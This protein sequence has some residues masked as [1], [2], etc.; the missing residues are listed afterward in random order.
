M[1]RKLLDADK[2]CI[3]PYRVGPS[4]SG[5]SHDVE[6]GDLPPEL[7]RALKISPLSRLQR[8]IITLVVNRVSCT[9][10]GGPRTGR[11]TAAPLT[12]VFARLNKSTIFVT[13]T[14]EAAVQ[15]AGVGNIIALGHGTLTVTFLVGNG[16]P[17]SPLSST[18]EA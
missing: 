14:K 11:T 1:V 9:V 7:M 8:T 15:A 18:S 13:P 17:A 12:V 16:G 3:T 4:N 6:L 2:F 10:T 5:G